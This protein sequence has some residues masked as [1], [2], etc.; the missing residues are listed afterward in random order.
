MEGEIAE[1]VRGMSA[2]GH[3]S[4]IAVALSVFT[5]C[6]PKPFLPA[7]RLTT[8][9]AGCHGDTGRRRR[10]VRPPSCFRPRDFTRGI[11]RSAHRERRV[12]TDDDIRRVVDEG[13]PGTAMPEWKSRLPE[14]ERRGDRLPQD[15]FQFFKGAVPAARFRTAPAE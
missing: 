12:P 4:R 2:T 14:Q 11:S 13:M 1:R 10:P 6:S 15:L 7:K 9:G 8:N 3:D 5:S